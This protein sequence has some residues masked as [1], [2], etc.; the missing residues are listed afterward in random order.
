M[1]KGTAHAENSPAPRRLKLCL[2]ASGG[3]HIRQ[4]L[5]LEPFWSRHDAYFVT[6][7]TALADSLAAT[8]RVRMVDH[9]AFGQART[10]SRLA[11]VGA[12]LRNLAKSAR[13]AWAERPD[14]VIS[15]GAGSAFFTALFG[16]L[17]GA[18]V[19]VIES[20]ARFSSPSLFGR[21]ARP[22]AW[23][24]VIQS[25]AL[26]RFWPDAVL[27]DP[28]KVWDAERPPKQPL[29]FV[30]VG[31]VLPFDRLVAG[32]A[33]L[34]A[35]GLLP[36]HVIAQVGAGGARP[37]GLEC[38]D[39]L[40][41]DEVKAILARADIVFCH[42]GTGSLVTALRAGCRVV[43]MARSPAAQE[44]YDDHQREI[45]DAFAGR[46]LIQTTDNA[47]RLGEALALARTMTVRRAS[48][49]PA[50]LIALLNEWL[51]APDDVTAP[52]APA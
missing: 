14:V 51:P 44:H 24:K 45:V 15:T 7:P 41:F 49:E 31:T 30:T 50:K 28:L 9:F 29:A 46:G 25:E 34:K 17:L 36:E 18:R 33:A 40:P 12:G 27:C 20:F 11:L 37:A 10:Q 8:R 52:A 23:R 3:G 19:I 5:D 4:L 13:H 43:A 26:A 47:D 32:V 1:H 48:T 35:A 22:L 39:S 38:H 42:G 2:A 16:R 21:L 6:E